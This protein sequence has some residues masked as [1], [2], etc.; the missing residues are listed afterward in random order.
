MR[1]QM[2]QN[3]SYV[4]CT[5]FIKKPNIVPANIMI[6]PT[7]EMLKESET[8]FQ[9]QLENMGLV[10]VA[11]FKLVCQQTQQLISKPSNKT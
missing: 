4:S 3:P 9:K 10:V 11:H 7:E 1:I 6:N 2:I 8:R 5:G